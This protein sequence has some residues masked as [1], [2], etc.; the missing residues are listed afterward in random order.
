VTDVRPKGSSSHLNLYQHVAEELATAITNGTY[1][2]GDRVPSV[3]QLARRMGVSI[4]TVTQAYG[5]LVDR[6]VVEARPQSGYF[7]CPQRMPLAP[8]P[9]T[10]QPAIQPMP[11]STSSLTL[12]MLSGSASDDRLHLDTAPPAADLLPISQLNRC[13]AT[14]LREVPTAAA[15]YDEPFGRTELRVQIARIMQYAGCQSG[16][17]D[18]LVTSGCQE[19]ITLCLRAV[20]KPGDTIAVE[21]PTFFGMLQAI[22]SLGMHALEIPTHPRA[23]VRLDALAQALEQWPIRACLL[24]PTNSNPLGASM[25]LDDRQRLVTLL[26]THDVPLIENDVLG[27]LGFTPGPRP[28]PCKAWDTDGNVLFCSSFSK[29]VGPGLRVGWVTPGRYAE[30]IRHLKLLTSFTTPTI[31]QLAIARFLASGQYERHLTRARSEYAQ[32]SAQ[33]G[34]AVATTFPHGTRVT[35]PAGGTVLWV[36]LPDGYDTMRLYRQSI[37]NGISIAPGVLFTAQRRY[38]NAL[39]LSAVHPFSERI[40]SAVSTLASLAHLQQSG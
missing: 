31:E 20:A 14:V 22:E 28:L 34:N 1:R 15:V 16:P 38:R 21:S 25:S 30:R 24:M 23:G 29:T 5:L 12:D 7:V 13:I 26:R 37:A 8:E 36:E 6:G 10:S 40:E 33:L 35:Q 9:G 4:S 32:R 19:A 39:R 27:D 17:D 18:V 3:R 11:V 2:V